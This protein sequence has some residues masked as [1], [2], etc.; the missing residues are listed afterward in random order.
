VWGWRVEAGFFLSRD[1]CLATGDSICLSLL[2]IFCLFT[3]ILVWKRTDSDATW[4]VDWTTNTNPMWA[5]YSTSTVSAESD[6][7]HSL[8][9]RSSFTACVCFVVFDVLYRILLLYCVIVAACVCFV[10]CRELIKKSS[11]EI[12]KSIGNL[13]VQRGGRV[14]HLFSFESRKK[15]LRDLIWDR[16]NC[17]LNWPGL[18]DSWKWMLGKW[19]PVVITWAVAFFEWFFCR[20]D[21]C[22]IWTMRHLV[23]FRR[24]LCWR[25]L[26]SIS[27]LERSTQRQSAT[28]GKYS[29][30]IKRWICS[31]TFL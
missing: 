9:T 15:R 20:K 4:D 17:V 25:T 13:Q 1:V 8:F 29:S 10:L 21:V 30:I 12:F 22:R 27:L 3:S 18:V 19:Y 28:D 11:E 31:W 26:N 6:I 5:R 16:N 7:L 14:H 24:V 23:L 2:F